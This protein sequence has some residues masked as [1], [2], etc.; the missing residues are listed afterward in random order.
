[1][2]AALLFFA[3]YALLMVNFWD[4]SMAELLVFMTLWVSLIVVYLT[5]DLVCYKIRAKFRRRRKKKPDELM[6]FRKLFSENKPH[7]GEAT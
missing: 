6:G 1:M 5:V 7:G 3:L 4:S 2:K